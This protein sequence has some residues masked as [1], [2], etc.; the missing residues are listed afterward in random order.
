MNGTPQEASRQPPMGPAGGPARHRSRATCE[1]GGK[2]APPSADSTHLPQVLTAA[3]RPAGHGFGFTRV[4]VKN[5]R[6]QAAG[7]TEPPLRSVRSALILAAGLAY[8]RSQA[9]SSGRFPPEA[10]VPQP[11]RRRASPP[12]GG[13]RRAR[14]GRASGQ[15]VPARPHPRPALP[16]EASYSC[17]LR[18]RFQAAIGKATPRAGEALSPRV[19]HPKRAEPRLCRKNRT[20]WCHR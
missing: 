9:P 19:Q 16:G 20:G 14:S 8:R 6:R 18:T 15:R 17:R 13:G 11:A 4:L 2:A 3:S 10:L 12:L 7:S 1:S 5:P